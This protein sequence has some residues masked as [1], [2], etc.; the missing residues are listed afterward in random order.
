[1]IIGPGSG[2]E[3][4]HEARPAR[5]GSAAEAV[6]EEILSIA[7]DLPWDEWLGAGAVDR[8][9]DGSLGVVRHAW[10]A[11]AA[12]DMRAAATGAG[13]LAG[14]DTDKER[15]GAVAVAVAAAHQRPVR[16]PHAPGQEP[17]AWWVAAERTLVWMPWIDTSTEPIG[18]A[19]LESGEADA[20][21]VTA[22]DA[23]WT[24]FRTGVPRRGARGRWDELP[25][26]FRDVLSERA[27]IDV[28]LLEAGGRW[29]RE[30]DAIV[31]R[32]RDAEKLRSAS[33]ALSR[34]SEGKAG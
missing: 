5:V 16:I 28:S 13:M 14:G 18:L 4:E 6:G 29:R 3:P 23:C 15:L 2:D 10:P 31:V 22:P 1:M 24:V 8:V 19:L 7:V 9:R 34:R 21:T 12:R 32:W 25:A 11:T 27:G 20:V 30:G 17:H 26:R 33:V